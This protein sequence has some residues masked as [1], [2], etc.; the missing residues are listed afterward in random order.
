MWTVSESLR[1]LCIMQNMTY[2]VNIFVDRSGRCSSTHVYKAKN[3]QTDNPTLQ[4]HCI[5]WID[6]FSFATFIM[7]S[8][9]W[10]NSFKAL[11]CKARPVIC[12]KT[13]F[14]DTFVVFEQPSLF[15][16]ILTLLRLLSYSDCSNHFLQNR[17]FAITVKTLS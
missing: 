10:G 8:I 2:S 9:V 1:T 3:K 6:G 4:E 7:P 5:C 13:Q 17:K 16:R 11:V 14:I 15:D 12:F